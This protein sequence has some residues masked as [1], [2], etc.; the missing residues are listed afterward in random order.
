MTISLAETLRS[1]A[2][3]QAL[4][5]VPALGES[6]A[7]K[8]ASTIAALLL[9]LA[10]DMESLPDRRVAARTEMRALLADTKVTDPALAADL[11]LLARGHLPATL[12]AQDAFLLGLV[13][14]VHAWADGHDPALA[15]RC[16][17]FLARRAASERLNPPDFPAG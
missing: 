3:G 8:T 13:G 9:M 5:V 2:L 7:G 17:A 6:Y 14:A 12:H 16:R 10:D 1:L 4:M 11:D 15:A